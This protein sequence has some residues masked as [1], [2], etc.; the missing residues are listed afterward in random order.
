MEKLKK[1]SL[2][3][4][5]VLSCS[6]LM[7]SCE[8]EDEGDDVIAGDDCYENLMDELE[9]Y[10]QK[11]NAYSA[12]PNS[13]TCSALKTSAL[14]LIDAATECG[15]YEEFGAAAQAWTDLDCSDFD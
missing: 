2:A 15:Y 11:I 8:S 10:Q 1:L 14:N 7:T 5:M 12:N 13:S 3:L 6:V 9:V 4:A